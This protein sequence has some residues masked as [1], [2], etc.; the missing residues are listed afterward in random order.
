VCERHRESSQL[1]R[2][3]FHRPVI[4]AIAL[5]TFL[6]S[7]NGLLFGSHAADEM[8]SEAWGVGD[9]HG[10]ASACGHLSVS[11][12]HDHSHHSHSDTDCCGAHGHHS[13]DFRS[14]QPLVVSPSFFSSR[15][16]FFDIDAAI[17]EVYLE[18]FI[19]PQQSCLTLL[20]PPPQPL[21]GPGCKPVSFG[22]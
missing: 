3:P 2:I 19:P 4:A 6:F 10:S 20:F 18:R 9:S 14:G 1:I 11:D 17:P 21:A 22:A 16:R 5:L 8:L 12:Q 7:A 13:H 15:R